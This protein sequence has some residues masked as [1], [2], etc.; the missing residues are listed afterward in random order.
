MKHGRLAA[1]ILLLQA[2][3]LLL[4]F[5]QTPTPRQGKTM[6]QLMDEALSSQKKE[7]KKPL[8]ERLEEA[9]KRDVA[10]A[11]SAYPTP[12]ERDLCQLLLKTPIQKYLPKGY[13]NPQISLTE[14]T[15]AERSGGMRCKISII[16]QGPDR[17]NVIR[18]RV[19]P[20]DAAAA[21]GLKSLAKVLPPDATLI[22]DD[23]SYNHGTVSSPG[24]DSPCM[25]FTAGDRTQTFVSCAD[26]IDGEPIVVS[27]VSS[28]PNDGNSWSSD[29]NGRAGKLLEAGIASL[30]AQASEDLDD[31]WKKIFG[32]DQKNK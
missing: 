4:A 16:L 32:K 31:V 24:R 29:T 21:R 11:A 14:M 26:Q 30:E 1:A 3:L 23:L 12:P 18:F 20:D 22:Y 2:F 9:I 25:V 19:Y 7:T 27:G 13:S 5:G 6:D 10:A 15:A 17:F 28:Q 8:S